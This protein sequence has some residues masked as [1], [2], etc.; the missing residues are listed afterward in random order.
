VLKNYET[1]S[2]KSIFLNNQETI[3]ESMDLSEGVPSP[4]R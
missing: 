2:E 4:T 1:K 3:S